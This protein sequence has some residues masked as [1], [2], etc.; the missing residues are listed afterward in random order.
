MKKNVCQIVCKNPLTFTGSGF[1][2]KNTP[3]NLFDT[4]ES[5]SEVVTHLLLKQNQ[6]CGWYNINK[7]EKNI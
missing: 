5:H 4:S 3:V 7:A 6:T 2:K 1:A